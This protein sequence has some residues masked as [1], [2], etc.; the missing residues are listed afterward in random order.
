MKALVLYDSSFGNTKQL[1]EVIATELGK[2]AETVFIENADPSELS[3]AELLVIG[4]PI[5]GFRPTEKMNK[6]LAQLKPGQLN[7]VKS[8]TFDT[9]VKVWIH[10]NAADP[11]A[12]KVQSAG[13]EIIV[14]QEY[15]YVEGKEGPLFPGEV[16]RAA[17]WA[18]Q[19]KEA[20]GFF[21]A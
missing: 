6:F 13:A 5:Q 9:R 14:K 21:N 20:S 10:G 7:R 19:I 17:V 3:R 18:K 16:E 11:M 8:A 12:R 15:F 4:S 1:A 2:E